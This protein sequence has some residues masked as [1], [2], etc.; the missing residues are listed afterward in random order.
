M[1]GGKFDFQ[2]EIDK[3]QQS[4]HYGVSRVEQLQEERRAAE[5]VE[6][7]KQRHIEDDDDDFIDNTGDD[8][9]KQMRK[10]KIDR[11][12]A[13]DDNIDAA[14]NGPLAQGFRNA[15]VK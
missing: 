12:E 6:S 10:V 1:S 5:L 15:K 13:P 2:K 11:Q 4:K 14:L 9:V 8:L 3:L 7:R